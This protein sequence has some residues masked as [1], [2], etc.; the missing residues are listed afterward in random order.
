[1]P[2]V[3]FTSL[4]DVDLVQHMGGDASIIAA[5]RVSTVGEESLEEL[6]KDPA[7]R[8]GLI[9]YLMRSRHGSPFEH[10]SMTF[11]ISAPIFVFRE[12]H[13]H[14]IGWSYSETSARYRKLEPEYYLPFPG[15]AMKQEG[16]DSAPTFVQD[17]YLWD[18]TSFAIQA[19]VQDADFRYREL[20]RKGVAKEVA[21]MLLPVNTMTSMYATCNARSLM[22]FLSLRVY[23]ENATFVSRPM[24]EIE[25][26]A[27]EMELKFAELFPITHA[28]FCKYGRV[29]P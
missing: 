20:L 15:R 11:F 1:M 12:F 23:D 18:E 27:Q 2:Q 13:R 29:G 4:L 9:N 14:R 28:A 8:E 25:L 3:Q 10:N 26:V 21:R 24:K 7:E 16:K 19:T 17:D 6:C 5:A 22:A